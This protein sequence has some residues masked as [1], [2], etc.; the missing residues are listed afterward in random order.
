MSEATTPQ[1]KR[2]RPSMKNYGISDSTEGMME[3]TWVDEQMAKSRNYW[4]CSTRPDGRPHAAPVWGVWVNGALYFGS[5][6]E[7][8]KARNLRANPEV[9]VHLESG[10]DTVIIE[11]KA[12]II[13]P[14][15]ALMKQIADAY[16]AKYKS[17]RPEEDPN[18]KFYTVKPS[19]VFAWIEHDFPRTATRWE[20]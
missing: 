13:T 11:G 4:V 9:V 1:P 12:E 14:D 3:W 8:Q 16:E 15:A 19:K 7:S 10:D 2:S 6:P 20:F 17:Y 5:D 18:A